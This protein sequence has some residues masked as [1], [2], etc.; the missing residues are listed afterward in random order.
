MSLVVSDRAIFEC[1]K[2]PVAACANVVAGVKLGAAL[3]DDDFVGD[4]LLAAKDL[5]AEALKDV[6]RDGRMTGSP[7]T[8]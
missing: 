6:W 3:A 4:D 5:D 7:E 1:E 8:E 2:R